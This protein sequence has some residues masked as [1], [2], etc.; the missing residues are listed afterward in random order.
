MEAELHAVRLPQREAEGAA[1]AGVAPRVRA[2]V[3][4]ADRN[5]GCQGVD[6]PRRLLLRGSRSEGLRS[7]GCRRQ[8]KARHAGQ[9]R[10]APHAVSSNSRGRTVAPRRGSAPHEG[11]VAR[12]RGRVTHLR[13]RRHYGRAGV[14]PLEACTLAAEHLP[15]QREP[16][17]EV[18]DQL[19]QR[20]I[21]SF[22]GALSVLAPANLI[23]EFAGSR[24][25]RLLNLAHDLLPLD[26]QLF[27][28]HGHPGVDLA[29]HHLPNGLHDCL[30][31][32]SVA[33]PVQR[34]VDASQGGCRLGRRRL[35][36]QGALEPG[37]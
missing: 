15:K 34:V 29:E 30:V 4:Q 35:L 9:L 17:G 11:R 14:L 22:E 21:L 13:G 18:V 27:S 7:H 10:G 32:Q 2:G 16:G 31:G 26:P 8:R 1:A 20:L 6:K 19:P 37:R 28:L 3:A 33:Q 24:L 5:A 36:R 23:H 12:L 25:V